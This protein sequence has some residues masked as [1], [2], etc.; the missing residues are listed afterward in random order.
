VTG[1]AGPAAR[2]GT[3]LPALLAHIADAFALG[4]V[5]NW[6]V[7]STGYEDCNVDLTTAAA[8]VVV[9]VFA[10]GRAAG[11]AARTAGLMTAA[12]AVGVHHPRLHR[13]THG[14]LVHSY[15]G[16]QTLVMDFVPGHTLYDLARAV[17]VVVVPFGQGAEQLH[18]RGRAGERAQRDPFDRRQRVRCGGRVQLGDLLHPH[19]QRLRAAVREVG[20]HHGQ[21]LH[22]G[23][24]VGHG[25]VQHRH[26]AALGDQ[27]VPLGQIGV[28]QRH[29]QHRPVDPGGF[30]DGLA[31]ETALLGVEDVVDLPGQRRQ[32]GDGPRVEHELQVRLNGVDGHGLLHD[33]GQ[34]AE[35]RPA[36]PGDGV[37][38]RARAGRAARLRAQLI[39]ACSHANA[40]VPFSRW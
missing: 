35:V 19:R 13:D 21:L 12:H 31:D 40:A 20:G 14:A 39:R 7:L 16:H 2:V 8:R 36:R 26:R 29:R 10:P 1:L 38:D 3:D 24:P 33:P 37:H 15:R 11:I 34:L 32:V 4:D 30:L 9:K 6:S 18:R 22:P 23:K 28:D 5:T 27:H 25:E 17:V